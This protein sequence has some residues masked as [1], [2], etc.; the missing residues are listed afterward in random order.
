MQQTSLKF[1]F[2][3]ENDPSLL[4]QLVCGTFAGF[5][6]CFVHETPRKTQT[7]PVAIDGLVVSGRKSFM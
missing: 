1:Y 7:V 3:L 2:N 5:V 4:T 6:S